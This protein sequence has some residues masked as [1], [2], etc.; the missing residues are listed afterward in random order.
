VGHRKL[1]AIIR[2]GHVKICRRLGHSNF[3]VL[4]ISAQRTRYLF[5]WAKY[6]NLVWKIKIKSL[7]SNC[8]VLVR[9]KLGKGWVIIF[10]H[11]FKGGL[12]IFVQLLR[13]GLP[14]VQTPNIWFS[15]PTPPFYFMTG[16]LQNIH[17][18]NLIKEIDV[19][20]QIG[21]TWIQVSKWNVH[22][23]FSKIT[24]WQLTDNN[25]K[26]VCV[27]VWVMY[28]GEYTTSFPGWPWD[29]G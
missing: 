10:Q 21:I 11:Q 27:C 8:N 28:S 2:V 22:N 4:K 24:T 18:T 14:K 29:Q 23:L 15:Q 16:P 13:G 7:E 6:R 20:I 17:T 5:F 1:S 12:Q 25:D 26:C 3:F 19:R 9:K